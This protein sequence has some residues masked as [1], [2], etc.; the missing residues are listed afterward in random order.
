MGGAT[1]ER[2]PFKASN[3]GVR[4]EVRAI[5]PLTSMMEHGEP[6][7]ARK[8]DV[9]KKKSKATSFKGKKQAK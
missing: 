3:D 1:A 7:K 9:S 6:S 4:E 5:Q 8:V 2:V